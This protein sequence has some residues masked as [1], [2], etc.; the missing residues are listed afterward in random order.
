MA[1]LDYQASTCDHSHLIDTLK[2][3][4]LLMLLDEKSEGWKIEQNFAWNSNWLGQKGVWYLDYLTE[5]GTEIQLAT[6]PST[7]CHVILSIVEFRDELW[8]H[9]GLNL[10]HMSSY[11]D[12]YNSKYS[13][14]HTLSCI[15]GSSARSRHD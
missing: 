3:K 5:K 1:E 10:L 8:D 9:Y 14:T 4:E 12:G 2:G 15:T 11:C 13:T 7:L 6:I